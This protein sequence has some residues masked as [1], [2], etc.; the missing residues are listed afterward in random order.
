M[1]YTIRCK[2]LLCIIDMW[3]VITLQPIMYFVQFDL[4]DPQ[5]K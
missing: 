2:K 4:H 3:T 1:F 5:T